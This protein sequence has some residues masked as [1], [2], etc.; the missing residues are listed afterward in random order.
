VSG[1]V[2][3]SWDI[4][5]GGQD[6]WKRAGAAE[7]MTEQTMKHARLQRDAFET[8]DK[9]WAARTITSDRVAALTRELNASRRVVTAYTKEYEIGQ[10]TL[11]DLLNAENQ[12]FNT[13]ASLVSAR[14]VAV[15][16]DYQL[17][18][19]MGQLLNYQKTPHPKEA[20]TDGESSGFFLPKL[21]PIY[22]KAPVIG[23]EPIN[24]QDGTAPANRTRAAQ[25]QTGT[26][27]F[28]SRFWPG[29]ASTTPAVGTKTALVGS[30]N[31][32]SRSL[33]SNPLSFAA[34]QSNTSNMTS[35]LFLNMPMWPTH[36]ARA[37]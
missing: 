37:D 29:D 1:K 17:L 16:A 10:R 18:A 21:A 26:T 33:S 25:S 3:M 24:L 2:V 14:G 12:Q 13:A 34:P 5:N 35:A 20:T 6:S 11:V 31:G 32:G 27:T 4:F 30:I 36:S 8:L 7:R 19:V 9:A 15:F 23:P 28:A 22:L